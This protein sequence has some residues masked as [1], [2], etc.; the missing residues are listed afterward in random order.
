MPAATSRPFPLLPL[1]GAAG[2]LVLGDGL[3]RLT[4]WLDA[5]AEASLPTWFTVAI[6]FLVGVVAWRRGSSEGRAWRCT[7][8]FFVYLAIDDLL[9]LHERFGGLAHESLGGHGIYAW[10]VL[11]APVFAI[12]GFVC[13]WQLLRALRQAP[14]QRALLLCGFAALA[15][16]LVGEAI[17][18]RMLA[19]PW[20]PRG[21]PLVCYTQWLEEALEIIG[22]VLLL[23]A[24][25]APKQPKPAVT[26]LQF[27]GLGR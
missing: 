7:G 24:I 16:A 22:P 15:L 4:H 27:I 19:S 21:I 6:T 10:V 3:L 23:A 18:D 13:A 14:R 25:S 26:T 20:R 9:S 17:E 11:L 5:T 12:A 2:L 1:L 8:A